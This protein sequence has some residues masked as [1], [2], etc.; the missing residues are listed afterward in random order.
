MGD[1]VNGD[2]RITSDKGK[3]EMLAATFFPSLPPGERAKHNRITRKW[4]AETGT[5]PSEVPPIR[6][7][8]ILRTVQRMRR[9]AAPGLDEISGTLLKI[10]IF[11]LLP[12]L[13]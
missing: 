12:F 9:A 1:L 8:K 6:E 10:C 11:I 4:R 5:F 7:T 13:W 3:A 2:E